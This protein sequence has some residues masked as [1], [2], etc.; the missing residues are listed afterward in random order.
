[1]QVAEKIT[2][3]TEIASLPVAVRPMGDLNA[4]TAVQSLSGSIKQDAFNA[5]QNIYCGDGAATAFLACNGTT[6]VTNAHA[7][8]SKTGQPKWADNSGEQ[9][10]SCEFFVEN[11]DGSYSAYPIEALTRKE[12]IERKQIGTTYT[13]VEKELSKDWAVV[14][15]KTPVPA[16]LAK[17]LRIGK[18]E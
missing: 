2:K 10:K 13:D 12:L 14:R 5:V 15:L 3:E 6:L 4:D 8:I 18:I 1:I 17:P 16:H 7:I 11:G 9:E